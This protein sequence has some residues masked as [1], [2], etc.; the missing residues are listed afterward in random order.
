MICN[1]FSLLIKTIQTD[2]RGEFKPFTAYLTEHGIR[3]RIIC[4]RTHHQNGVVERKHR[5][6][7]D[8]GLTLLVEAKL[9]IYFWDHAFLTAVFII[10]RLPSAAIN[11]EI[12][13]QLLFQQLP[14]YNFLCVFG[15]SCFPLLRP[16]NKHKL[17][18]RSQ[19]CLFLG[20]STSHKGYKC[21]SPDGRL[22][23]SKDVIFNEAKFP[24]STLF[25]AATT[26]TDTILETVSVRY[27]SFS[28]SYNNNSVQISPL[29]T[30]NSQP[31]LEEQH[32]AQLSHT[33]TPLEAGSIDSHS[34]TPC[35][36]ADQPV[37]TQPNTRIDPLNTHPMQTRAK[38]GIIQPKQHF[39][40]LLTHL[41][42]KTTKQA[43]SNPTWFLAMKDEYDALIKNNTWELV[44][45]PHN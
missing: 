19:E 7:A 30:A 1:Q 12:P 28:H 16:Y 29:V 41:E 25:E 21:L 15:C 20:Y 23:I 39:T 17:Q 2:W 5:H 22:Y 6:I 31:T 36:A 40:L 33:Q 26:P 45:L 24:Y 8:L 27:L 4:P 9:P 14:D 34:N 42:P 32:P 13:F 38:T 43:L 3:H 44:S 11:K 10:N 18:F 35:T 37:A